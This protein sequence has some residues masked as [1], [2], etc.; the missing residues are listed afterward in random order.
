MT[1]TGTKIPNLYMESRFLIHGI[2]LAIVL[3]CA[4]IAMAIE[5]NDGQPQKLVTL[6]SDHPAKEGALARLR[7]VMSKYLT[8]VGRQPLK[9]FA[10]HCYVHLMPTGVGF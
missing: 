4:T 10:W 5:K 8:S 1:K 9:K 3:D 2:A 6:A 7:Q